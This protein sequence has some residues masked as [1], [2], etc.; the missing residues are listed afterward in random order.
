MRGNRIRPE[1]HI[2]HSLI[3]F[4]IAASCWAAPDY[5]KPVDAWDDVTGKLVSEGSAM[6]AGKTEDSLAYELSLPSLLGRGAC[7]I[8]L[9]SS[10]SLYRLTLLDSQLNY[11]R[12]TP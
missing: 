2:T 5:L 3:C 8:A 11:T 12:S 9:L 10:W 4:A 6:A 1:W 7:T